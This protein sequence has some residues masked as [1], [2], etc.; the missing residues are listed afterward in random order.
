MIGN[1][2]MRP[3]AGAWGRGKNIRE[4]E[5]VNYLDGYSSFHTS[6]KSWKEFTLSQSSL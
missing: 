4:N 1:S 5:I 6:E 2:N 3:Q